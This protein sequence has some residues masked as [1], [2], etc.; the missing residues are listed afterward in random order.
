QLKPNI[1]NSARHLLEGL[2]QKDRTKRLGAKDD[3][4]ELKNHVFFSPVSWGDLNAKKLT[5]PF[6]PNVTGPNDLRHFDPEFTD[7]PVP[8]SIG[9]SPDSALMTAS[10]KEAAEAFLGFSY[11][12][13]MDSYL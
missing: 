3:F 12:P 8:S 13:S 4:T 5:P 6:N 11:A 7:E 9:R 2:L 10:I 1:S